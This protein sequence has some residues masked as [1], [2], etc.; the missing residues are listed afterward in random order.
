MA[1]DLIPADI[2]LHDRVG[3]VAIRSS[4]ERG[5]TVTFTYDGERRTVLVL[6]NTGMHL[7]GVAKERECDYRQYTMTKIVGIQYAK[8][9]VKQ[10]IAV[11]YE[12]LPDNFP[13]I[14]AGR[15]VHSIEF[16]N[17][18]GTTITLEVYNDGSSNLYLAGR[19]H[20][21]SFAHDK[22]F[23]LFVAISNFLSE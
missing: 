8:P 2:K 22:P 11:S 17:R 6:E 20:Y 18:K 13:Q 16:K 12:V 5:D 4:V 21:K 3:R 7:K 15:G 19:K 1:V 9:F 14:V 23:D 10:N